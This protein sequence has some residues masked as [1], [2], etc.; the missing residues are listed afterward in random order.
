[1]VHTFIQSR[2]FLENHT[3]FS[4]EDPGEGSSPLIFK[5]KIF[6]GDRPPSPYLRVGDRAPPYLKDWIWPWFQTKMG[7]IYTRLRLKRRKNPTLWG[8][9]YLYG[10]YKGVL[11][12]RWVYGLSLHK[13]FVC[14][15]MVGLGLLRVVQAL[16]VII[17]PLPL[18]AGVMC[19]PPFKFREQGEIAPKSREEGDLPSC[20]SPLPSPPR[21]LKEARVR[22]LIDAS[23]PRVRALLKLS[24]V[25]FKRL[26]SRFSSLF[27][28]ASSPQKLTFWLEL[29]NRYPNSWKFHFTRLTF[30]VAQWREALGTKSV[31]TRL[32]SFNMAD[33]MA[34]NWWEKF[35]L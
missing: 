10:L 20:T 21:G 35:A 25:F 23:S 6:F 13:I 22:T 32:P 14:T 18:S 33:E 19:C 17:L 24:S 1:M 5:P 15:H 8:G 11:P 28:A 3:Q 2:S 30:L 4:V 16:K 34:G 27:F 12:R 9:T 7:K 31:R 26:R 29:T